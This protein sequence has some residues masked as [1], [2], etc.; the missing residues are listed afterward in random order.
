[1]TSCMPCYA[2][3]RMSCGCVLFVL[4][5]LIYAI[6]GSPT[7]DAYGWVEIL[8]ALLLLA[9]VRPP[10]L[11]QDSFFLSVCS[12]GVF[13]PLL[14]GVI[15]GAD[16]LDIVRD[17]VPFLFLFL[18][19]I[20]K[21]HVSALGSSFYWLLSVMG[22]VFSV[23]AIIPYLDGLLTG[24]AFSLGAPADLLYLANSP[25]V[26]FSALWLM[27]SGFV[28]FFYERRIWRGGTFLALSAVPLL[29]MALMMQRAGLISVF[30]VL[31]ALIF[32]LVRRYPSR[33]ILCVLIFG[34]V[35]LLL[36]PILSFLVH[37]LLW[38]THV[39]GLNSR[40]QEWHV[41]LSF[42]ARDWIHVLFGYGWGMR[43]ENPAVGGLS[44]LYTHSL[45]SALLL[46]TGIIGA[47]VV[48]GSLGL[49]VFRAIP[50]VFQNR[51]LFM[52]LIFPLIISAGI[53]AS[54]KS[55]GFG[56]ILLV[57]LESAHQKL[58]KKPLFVS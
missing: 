7:P 31:C 47:V 30:L 20:Y 24:G 3:W 55:L 36:W 43:I 48:L 27:G 46:K 49:A 25:E 41:V 42:V 6:F 14:I 21:D 29:S 18:V 5:L 37:G 9:S 11:R 10:H 35:G 17:L 19:L 8:I 26:L 32:G 34:G 23:R 45:V 51:I 15:A 52:A 28:A 53:Y 54:Y 58:E 44:V 39:V 1:M 2:P 22:F 38:K 33:W 4:A 57:F 56:L 16:I 13:V 50:L 40:V 12:Y